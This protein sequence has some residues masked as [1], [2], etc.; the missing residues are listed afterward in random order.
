MF[1]MTNV[2][3]TVLIIDDDVMLADLLAA[4]VEGADYRPLVAADGT[5]GIALA[6][7]MAPDVVFCDMSMPG[8]T[9]AEVLRTIRDQPSTARVPL[10]LM[11]GDQCTDLTAIGANAF[12][13]KPFLPA[14]VLNL[15]RTL[16]REESALAA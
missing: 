13:S 8:L 11:S 16:L 12:L 9:G 1:L 5:E 10:V 2:P 3:R 4:I 6:R 7:T 14:A 15:L